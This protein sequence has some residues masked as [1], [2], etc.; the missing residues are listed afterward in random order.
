M[1]FIGNQLNYIIVLEIKEQI[2][3]IA[4]YTSELI[5]MHIHI[6]TNV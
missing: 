6:H 3:Q 2:Q 4:V 1:F 5:Y